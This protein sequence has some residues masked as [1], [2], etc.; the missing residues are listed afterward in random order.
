MPEYD[1]YI[2]K[3]HGRPEDVTIAVAMSGGVDS[4][5]AAAIL[6]G[7]GYR[8]A[9]FT[10]KLWCSDREYGSDRLCCTASSME[11]AADV[12]AH[13]G[14]PHYVVDLKSEFRSRVIERF[15]K[16]YLAGRTPNPCVVCNAEIKLGA[17]MEKA[18]DMGVDFVATGHHIRQV[19]VSQE[20]I[21]KAG[22]PG[23]SIP[24]GNVPGESNS[25]SR[26][27]EED[28]I[29]AGGP[30]PGAYRLLKGLDPAK[31]QSYALWR[32][33]QRQLKHT[34]FP[35]GWLTKDAVRD[36][37]RRLGLAS[38]EAKESQD[39]CFIPRGDISDLLDEVLPGEPRPAGGE[40]RDLN[41]RVLGTH[42]GYYKFTLGQRRGLHLAL[43]RRQYIVK[44]DPARNVVYVGDEEDLRSRVARLSEFNFIE[45]VESGPLG[46][47]AVGA[48]GTEERRLR[49]AAKIRYMHPAAPG[50]L[51]IINGGEVLVTFDEPQ[52]AITPGQSLVAYRGEVLVG[53]GVIKRAER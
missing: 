19:S 40:I 33:T 48:E 30:R 51:E 27:S 32:V 2:R 3:E 47:E 15:C 10:L 21:S 13:L 11:T 12:C 29:H 28:T 14:V 20:G 7:D 9:G 38:S 18:R 25:A 39:V 49:V 44:I 5:V 26:T 24:E 34:V 22:V 43:G 53:G 41:E 16:E 45:A 6:A 37:A 1:S 31:D 46:R 35:I 50:W 36:V 4:S 8:V 52:R 17:L 42:T 23:G